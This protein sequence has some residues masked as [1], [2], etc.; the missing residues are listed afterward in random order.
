MSKRSGWKLLFYSVLGLVMLLFLLVVWP[1]PLEYRTRYNVPDYP[2]WTSD[3][4]TPWPNKAPS[5][6]LRTNRFTGR[7]EGRLV[8]SPQWRF[9]GQGDDINKDLLKYPMPMPEP[10]Y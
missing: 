1:T 5:Y 10:V 8:S 2:Y 7:T 6:Y 4:T 9:V 3:D